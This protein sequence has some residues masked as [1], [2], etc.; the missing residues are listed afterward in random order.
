[1]RYHSF[2]WGIF[3]IIQ[4][5]MS[6][7]FFVTNSLKMLVIPINS[8]ET[9]CLSENIKYPKS[10]WDCILW[11]WAGTDSL[12]KAQVPNPGHI[13]PLQLPTSLPHQQLNCL[14]PCLFHLGRPDEVGIPELFRPLRLTFLSLLWT[15][16]GV[17]WR[18]EA[19][20]L[21]TEKELRIIL[22]YDFWF[23]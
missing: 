20:R 16:G 4:L 12:R 10:K 14:G 19:T 11:T 9:I 5:G 17:L 8:H 7:F 23:Q 1:M 6:Q 18:M 13:T 3:K 21:P 22:V 2:Q 15:S